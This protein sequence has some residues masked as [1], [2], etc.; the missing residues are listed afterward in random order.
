M[1]R[2]L[3]ILVPVL[4]LAACSTVPSAPD[5]GWNSSCTDTIAAL[6]P[7]RTDLGQD[8]RAWK[9]AH[10][11]LHEYVRGNYAAANSDWRKLHVITGQPADLW[12][13]TLALAKLENIDHAANLLEDID[14][15]ALPDDHRGDY[16]ALR[17]C[18]ESHR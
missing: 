9:L 15:D 5:D 6:H 1:Q 7:I 12:N 3:W 8:L 17:E 2:L 13:A 16:V 10:E 18:I 14:V 4:M 11:A